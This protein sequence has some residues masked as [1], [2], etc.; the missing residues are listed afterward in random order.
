MTPETSPIIIV[1][2][3]PKPEIHV[4]I[5]VCRLSIYSAFSQLLLSLQRV[6]RRK[7]LGSRYRQRSD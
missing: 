2:I 7:G 3:I 1:P 6:C 4:Y 5:H